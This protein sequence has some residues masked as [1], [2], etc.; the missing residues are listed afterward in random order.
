[1]ASPLTATLTMFSIQVGFPVAGILVADKIFK[2]QRSRKFRYA[3]AITSFAFGGWYLSNY[4][5]TKYLEN[6]EITLDSEFAEPYYGKDGLDFGRDTQGRFRRKLVIP[7]DFESKLTPVQKAMREDLA[8]T[9]GEI[10]QADKKLRNL[11]AY[12]MELEDAIAND[13]IPRSWRDLKFD[14]A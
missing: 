9:E 2:H 1:M 11:K 12:R 6:V 8:R 5:T 3:F 10:Y 13:T 4:F 7:L 14:E